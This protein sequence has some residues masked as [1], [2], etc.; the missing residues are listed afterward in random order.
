MPKYTKVDKQRD[1]YGELAWNKFHAVKSSKDNSFV[2]PTNR[3]FFDGP[4]NYNRKFNTTDM[5]SPDFYRKNAPK[6][7]VARLHK[8]PHLKSLYTK[9]PHS[10]S[11]FFPNTTK[12]QHSHHNSKSFMGKRSDS[13]ANKQ[14]F[15]EMMRHGSFYDTPFI[16]EK[17]PGNKFKVRDEVKQTMSLA[18]EIPFLRTQIDPQEL[19][20]TQQSFFR[21]NLSNGFSTHG[22]TSPKSSRAGSPMKQYHSPR[23]AKK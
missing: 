14:Q 11:T 6:N 1:I 3:E 10:A 9:N 17:E 22:R 19:S 12:N 16:L 13:I 15:D 23:K 7:S 2:Y 8:R 4:R 18:S 21:P 20:K 5:T